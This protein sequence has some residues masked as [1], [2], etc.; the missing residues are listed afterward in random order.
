MMSILRITVIKL[1]ETPKFLINEGCDAEAVET[2]QFIT[3]KYNRPYS[4]T[5]ERL[6]ACDVT[7]QGRLF[8]DRNK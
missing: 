3:T 6:S 2:L 5:L 7:G 8:V 4:L 1:R